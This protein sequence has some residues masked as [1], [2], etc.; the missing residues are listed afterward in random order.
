MIDKLDVAA[1]LTGPIYTDKDGYNWAIGKNGD[2]V[3]AVQMTQTRAIGT[4]EADVKAQVDDFARSR[5]PGTYWTT[6]ELVL[7]GGVGLLA[8]YF[9]AKSM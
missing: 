7:A 9:V 4:S 5:K 6:T 2:A 8:G 1:N 3:T